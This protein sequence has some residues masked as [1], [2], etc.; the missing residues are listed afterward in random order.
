MKSKEKRKGINLS[1]KGAHEHR[2]LFL[3][4]IL[5]L[6]PTCTPFGMSGYCRLTSLLHFWFLSPNFSG[7]KTFFKKNFYSM[8]L[9]SGLCRRCFTIHATPAAE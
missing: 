8:V 2:Q 7:G 3:R 5:K 1:D 9:T 6:T 4:D